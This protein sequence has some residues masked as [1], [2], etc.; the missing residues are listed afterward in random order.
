MQLLDA[1]LLREQALRL[2]A[3]AQQAVSSPY[4]GSVE[5][6]PLYTSFIPRKSLLSKTSTTL[7]LLHDAHVQR[8]IYPWFVTSTCYY[9]VFVIS[10]SHNVNTQQLHMLRH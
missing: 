6:T 5:V 1:L 10:H 3:A 2:L 7:R 8:V 9:Y 4:V